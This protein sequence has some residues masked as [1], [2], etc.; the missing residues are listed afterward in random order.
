MFR[1]VANSKD[2]VHVSFG[3]FEPHPVVADT[4]ARSSSLSG[5]SSRGAIRTAVCFGLAQIPQV[6]DDTAFG[7]MPVTAKGTAISP[8]RATSERPA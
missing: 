8:A 6:L 2:P 1:D 7:S 5:S 3:Y 4:L